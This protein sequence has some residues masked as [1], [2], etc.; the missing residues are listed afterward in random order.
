MRESSWRVQ[1]NV[2]GMGHCR[3]RSVCAIPGEMKRKICPAS[4]SA[5]VVQDRADK[6]HNGCLSLR[7][8]QRQASK[9]ADFVAELQGLSYANEVARCA[10]PKVSG[11]GLGRLDRALA[12]ASDN[13]GHQEGVK[14]C[15]TCCWRFRVC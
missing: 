10:M 7:E 1:R 11:R 5:A 8:G 9:L 13:G 15:A 6:V 4:C 12:V 3:R 14:C 2:W